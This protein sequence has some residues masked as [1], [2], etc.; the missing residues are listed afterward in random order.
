[1]ILT[2][3]LSV[4]AMLLACMLAV[5]AWSCSDDDKDDTPIVVN[6]LPQA[7]KTFISTYYA[8]VSVAGVVRDSDHGTIE[9]DVKFVNGHEVTFNAAG[10]WI[11]VDAPTGSSIPDGIAPAA[12]VEYLTE[13]FPLAGINE[14][15]KTPTG[16]EVELTTNVD[17]LFNADGSFAGF[18]N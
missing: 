8:G 15:S 7:A 16:Y 2:K 3:K 9:Y 1:M 10:E 4:T 11:D 6:D 17:L 13:N 18:D 5:T 12:I 14:I